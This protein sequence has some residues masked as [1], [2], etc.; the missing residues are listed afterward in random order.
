MIISKKL[1]PIFILLIMVLP[2]STQAQSWWGSSDDK[3]FLGVESDRIS[4]NKAE[5]LGYDN[6]YGVQIKRIVKNSAAEEAGLLPFDYITAI[7]EE[8]MDWTT[9]LTDLLNNYESGDEATV[10]YIRQG[11]KRKVDLT[12]GKKRN[13]VFGSSFF[14]KSVFGDDDPFLGISEHRGHDNQTLGVKVN[15]VDGSTADDMGLKDGDVVMKI[16][17]YTMVD[18]SDISRAINMMNVGDKVAIDFE[19][20]G[21]T[22]KESS[23]IRT[24]P[25]KDYSFNSFFNSN[26][27]SN[28][29]RAFLGIYSG[30]MSKEKAK[31]LGFENRYG[32]YVTS[33]FDNS[34]AQEAGLQPFDY[35]YGIDEYRVGENQ[36]LTSILRKFDVGEEATIHFTRQGKDYQKQI[37]FGKRSIASSRNRSRCEDPFLGVQPSH[38]STSEKGTRVS[39]VDRS[40]ASTLG[41]RDGDVINTIN[42]FPI[43]D[44]S[45]VGPAIDMMEVGDPIS[46]VYYR[47]GQKK[48][49]EGKIASRCDSNNDDSSW[50]S[51]FYN[52]DEDVDVEDMVFDFDDLGSEEIEDVN[53]DLD[54]NLTTNIGLSVNNLSF[55]PNR[56]LQVFNLQFELPQNGKTQIKIYNDN[57]RQIYN[58]DLGYF[59]GEFSDE[60]DLMKEGEGEYFLEIKQGDQGIVKKVTIS[61]K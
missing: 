41:M 44:W 9:D 7:G 12:F 61:E 14:T 16:N 49:A 18:W 38:R 6:P 32:S 57:G 3:A 43:I 1:A 51:K 50:S 30:D 39:V 19:R 29:S 4:K 28:S 11:Q 56:D 13:E 26:S 42:G 27:N 59:S 8:S 22:Y 45:D 60:V 10:Y 15:V 47:A 35:I 17:G 23:E 25:K 55:S 52:D 37:T 58:Y 46:I 40:T 33:V 54:V 34:A 31:K 5:L 24:K 36:S 48:T 20:E 21:Q 53:D 2:L